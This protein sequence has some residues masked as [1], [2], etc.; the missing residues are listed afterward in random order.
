M[1]AFIKADADKPRMDLLP[2]YA[3]AAVARVLG[4]GARKYSTGNWRKVDDHG[5][6]IAAALRHVFA[7]MTGEKLDAESGEPHM[8]HACCCLLFV[9]DLESEP[10]S[11]KDP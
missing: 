3:I 11:R 8:A 4:F 5:R 1:S 2:P 9:L 10:L 7:H 6:Y